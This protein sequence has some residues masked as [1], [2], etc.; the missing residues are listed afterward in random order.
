[1]QGSFKKNKANKE[2]G[3]KAENFFISRLNKLGIPYE[4]IDEWYD[5]EVLNQKVEVKSARITIKAVQSRQR[6]NKEKYAIGRFDFTNKDNREL[7]YDQNI[8]VCFILRNKEDFLIL[9]LC[10]ARTLNK[11]RYITIHKTRDLNLMSLKEWIEKL[12]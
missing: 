9:G 1:M 5:F 6:Y 2:K 3:I 10:R 8:W 4:Y 11:K 7:Q 12:N